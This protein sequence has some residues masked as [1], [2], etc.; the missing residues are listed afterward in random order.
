MLGLTLK[1]YLTTRY[2]KPNH[3]NRVSKIT[4][5][6]AMTSLSKHIASFSYFGL[7]Q[8]LN[9]AKKAQIKSMIPTHRHL[10]IQAVFWYL[11]SMFWL[12]NLKLSLPMTSF[13]NLLVQWWSKIKITENWSPSITLLQRNLWSQ[14]MN[15]LRKLHQLTQKTLSCLMTIKICP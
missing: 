12:K 15:S 7:K 6:T 10:Q 5:M 13:S 2:W 3:L 9:L 14:T 8:P 1:S 11:H 4:S